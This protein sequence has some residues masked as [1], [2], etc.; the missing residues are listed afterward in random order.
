MFADG[1]ER[2][3]AEQVR[4]YIEIMGLQ[5]LHFILRVALKLRFK[6]QYYNWGTNGHSGK[7][8]AAEDHNCADI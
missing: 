7:R 5:R 8:L 4:I 3:A 1:S 6:R 2:R